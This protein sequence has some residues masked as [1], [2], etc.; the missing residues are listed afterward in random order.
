MEVLLMK[1]DKKLILMI[2]GVT[3]IV[4]LTGGFSK[5]KGTDPYSHLINMHNMKVSMISK[6]SPSSL[7]PDGEATIKDWNKLLDKIGIKF[8]V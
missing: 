4:L 3:T 7:R 2:S 6:Q 5:G 8:K 1:K